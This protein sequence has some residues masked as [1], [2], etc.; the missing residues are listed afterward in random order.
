[1]AFGAGGLLVLLLFKR[2]RRVPG[3]LVAVA[4]STVLA[5]WLGMEGRGVEIVGTIPQGLPALIVI[6]AFGFAIPIAF[7][8]TGIEVGA[9]RSRGQVTLQRSPETVRG[10][11]VHRHDAPAHPTETLA[12]FWHMDP[13][14]APR[15][16][17]MDL[18][19]ENI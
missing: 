19:R 7:G 16:R 3:A 10:C 4:L 9:P 14:H 1:M 15:R 13:A 17:G 18:A 2:W 11:A 5:W 8:S 12:D 6:I